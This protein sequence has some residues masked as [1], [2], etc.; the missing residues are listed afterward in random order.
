V[1]LNILLLRPAPQERAVLDER[2]ADVVPA[3][4][5]REHEV[6]QPAEQ[7]EREVPDEVGSDV[8]D[9][10]VLREPATQ[11]C[12]ERRAA[13]AVD[14]LPLEDLGLPRYFASA[15]FACS[16]IS[17]NLA[18][19]ETARSASTLRSRSISAAFRPAMNWLYERPFARA[20][21]L[22][23]MIQS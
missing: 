3:R 21:A 7:A 1:R 18:G 16:A 4:L 17:P 19:S 11:C 23:R 14:G 22:I 10:R 8:A 9:P 15:D 12:V 20:P 6:V 2:R 13:V 5:A